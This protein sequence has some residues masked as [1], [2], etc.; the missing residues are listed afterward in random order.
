MPVS[1]REAFAPRLAPRTDLAIDALR[2]DLRNLLGAISLDLEGL[3]AKEG[4]AKRI[5]LRRL[6]RQVAFAAAL[7]A[8]DGASALSSAN[9][10]VVPVADVVRAAAQPAAGCA[11]LRVCIP[12]HW[13]IPA[14]AAPLV[15]RAVFNLVHNA[16]KAAGAGGRIEVTRAPRRRALLISDN[17]PGLPEDAADS[18]F[19]PPAPGA[20]SGWGLWIAASMAERAGGGLELLRSDHRGTTF[21]LS[22]ETI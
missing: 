7:C 22:L 13:A 20:G 11:L 15:G 21:L 18:L 12:G 19:E 9:V 6:E 14:K 10:G 5:V 4:E 2:H 16:A 8:A 1:Q 17:G 3:T